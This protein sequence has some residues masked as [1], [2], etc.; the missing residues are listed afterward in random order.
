MLLTALQGLVST[1]IVHIGAQFRSYGAIGGGMVLLFWI[2][3]SCQ[4]VLL[5]CESTY[6]YAH[7]Y[8]SRRRMAL[9]W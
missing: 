7:L 8:G 4:I 6:V 3:L 2:Y 1:N 5:S 9:Q